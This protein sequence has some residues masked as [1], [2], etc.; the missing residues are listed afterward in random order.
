MK[1]FDI[2]IHFECVNMRINARNKHE[3][4]KKAVSRLRKMNP[5]N[6]IRRN[7]PDNKRMIEIE[8]IT[9]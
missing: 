8:E 5:Y 2:D 7:Y 3:A 1:T 9:W 6:F 4:R